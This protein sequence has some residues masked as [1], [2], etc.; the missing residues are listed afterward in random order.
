MMYV[1]RKGVGEWERDGKFG[2]RKINE[3]TGP[4]PSDSWRCKRRYEMGQS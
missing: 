4:G 3:R 1:G 2:G